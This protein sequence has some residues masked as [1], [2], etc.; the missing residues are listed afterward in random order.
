MKNIN[1][2]DYMILSRKI[3]HKEIQFYSEFFALSGSESR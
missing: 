2:V 3:S 1:G